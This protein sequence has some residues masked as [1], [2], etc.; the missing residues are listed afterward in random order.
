MNDV[1][2]H[3]VRPAYRAGERISETLGAMTS[4]RI[5]ERETV[6]DGRGCEAVHLVLLAGSNGATP[7][8]YLCLNWKTIRKYCITFVTYCHQ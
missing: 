1:L 3:G 7:E 4:G 2:G 8:H 6:Q 5:G